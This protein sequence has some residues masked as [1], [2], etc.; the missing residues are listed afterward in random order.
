MRVLNP[1]T[2][3]SLARTE[4][5]SRDLLEGFSSQRDVDAETG[6]TSCDADAVIC[7]QRGKV[8]K[9]ASDP[10]SGL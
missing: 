3:T 5:I 6:L 7:G 9:E 2:G 10:K 1:Y 8:D 4:F